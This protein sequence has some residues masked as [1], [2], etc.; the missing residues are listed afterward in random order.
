MAGRRCSKTRT[1]LILNTAANLLILHSHRVLLP[2]LNILITKLI[3]DL[4]PSHFFTSFILKKYISVAV[5]QSGLSLLLG[6]SL[7]E[8]TFHL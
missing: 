8:S 3:E 1:T 5:D 2:Y 7:V 4:S 6:T